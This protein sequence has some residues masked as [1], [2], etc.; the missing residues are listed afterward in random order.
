MKNCRV[1]ILPV[2]LVA[3]LSSVYL[4]PSAGTTQD[5]AV[6]MN[7]PEFLDG[8]YFK[9]IP[10]S[11]EE[12]GVL[13]KDTEFSKAICVMPI[14]GQYNSEGN[15][16]LDR[17]DLSIVLSGHDLNNSIHRPERCM[18]AQGH[19]IRHSSTRDFKLQNGHQISFR[20]LRSVQSIP[21]NEDQSEMLNLNCL[22]YYFF[23]GH[24]STTED[25]LT[26]TLKDIATR[27]FKG[28]DQRWAYV[29]ASVWYGDTPW[30]SV[31]KTEAEADAE[32]SE[33]MK[34]FAKTQID[35]SMIDS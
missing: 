19:T 6:K 5:S 10:P 9:Q 16:M 31:P 4:L 7:L 20:R 24:D 12:I 27:L 18:P 22:T 35:W 21:L 15:Q 3:L 8:W 11:S 30:T 23:V 17:I 2:F 14:P 13:A 28:A 33:F 1:Y 29:S 26:R 25:H 32:L 34:N